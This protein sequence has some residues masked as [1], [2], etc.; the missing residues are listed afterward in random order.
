MTGAA[1]V[2]ALL[3]GLA[4]ARSAEGPIVVAQAGSYGGTIGKQDKGMSGDE[5]EPRRAPSR[6]YRQPAPRARESRAPRYNYDGAWSVQGIGQNCVNNAVSAVVISQ[7]RVV[8]QGATGSVSSS[9]AVRIV[10]AAGSITFTSQGQLSGQ[11]GAGTYRQSDGCYG[12]WIA[13]RQ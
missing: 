8:A 11:G 3:S 7:G 5:P 13:S 6:G 9:G 12:R 4:P 1:T 10:G 2:L